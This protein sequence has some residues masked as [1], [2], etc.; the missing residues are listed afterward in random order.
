MAVNT[1]IPS[2]KILALE[3]STDFC[4]VSLL[5]GEDIHSQGENAGQ[6]HSEL[7]LPMVDE[8]LRGAGVSLPDLDAIA[9]GA[10]PGSFTGLRIACGVAQGLA[11]SVDGR[12]IPV[13]SL[14][15]LAQASGGSSVVICTDA[16]MGQVY[17]AAFVR[18]GPGWREVLA[19][20]LCSP[21][22][23]PELP[24][25]AWLGCGSGFDRYPQIMT[26]AYRNEVKQVI[27]GMLP[28]ARE[29]AML[30]AQYLAAGRSVASAEAAPIYVRNKV[31][32]TMK[33]QG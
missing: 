14:E 16:R 5:D 21:D 12:C 24:K 7:L 18:D 11:F 10:G 4:S 22:D 32:L 9:F 30:G 15:A 31:A 23:L 26:G 27:T 6:R 17:H 20:S 33:E 29:V 28:N 25:A 3:T 8:V 2:F 1:A 13:G 19:P